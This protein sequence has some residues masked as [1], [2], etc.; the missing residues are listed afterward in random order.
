LSDLKTNVSLIIP[1]TCLWNLTVWSK[2]V[3]H[4]RDNRP[5]MPI[6]AFFHTSTKWAKVSLKFTAP[7]LTLSVHHVATFNA[8][9]SCPSIFQSVSEWQRDNEDWSTKRRFGDFNWLSWQRPLRDCQ[10]NANF[11]K[12]FHSSTNLESL[13]KI[14]P[15]VR[16]N[17]LL[18]GRP[19]KKIKN[20]STQKTLA[21]YITCRAS[22]PGR[23]NNR[24]KELR[25]KFPIWCHK[26]LLAV[27][28]YIA[29]IMTENY[30]HSVIRSGRMMTVCCCV[31][32]VVLVA[33]LCV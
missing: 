6:F 29:N 9:L 24:I 27:T 19:L 15:V 20:R 5:D 2:L 16:E 4:V 1:I 14:R 10:M 26:W 33:I 30:L 31:I 8:L 22:M 23:L 28:Y 17:S 7:N 12:P 11:I 18:I 21:K 13:V 3:V 32:F 25:W